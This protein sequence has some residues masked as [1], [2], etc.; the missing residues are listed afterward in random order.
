MYDFGE[1]DHFESFTQSS[2]RNIPRKDSLSSK[3]GD[4]RKLEPWAN[5][6]FDLTAF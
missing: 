1:D 4:L 3:L 5:H 2:K 6:C